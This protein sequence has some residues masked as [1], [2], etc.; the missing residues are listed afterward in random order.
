MAL[1]KL[2]DIGESFPKVKRARLGVAPAIEDVLDNVGTPELNP[3]PQ[4]T[5]PEPPSAIPEPATGQGSET[6]SDDAPRAKT[7]KKKEGTV[8]RTGQ[9]V[10]KGS[11]TDARRY[12][13][14]GRTHQFGA[15]T[16]LDFAEAIKS[17]A[18]EKNMTIGEL[19][20]DMY[21]FYEPGFVETVKL[22]AVEKRKSISA[23]LIDM[24]NAYKAA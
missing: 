19:L 6:K 22:L 8:R 20:E 11:G 18:L 2:V 7:L 4:P 14:T 9:G 24:L 1:K 13:T 23:L 3:T 5:A 17:R 15:R 16:K 12:R 21:T 10:H